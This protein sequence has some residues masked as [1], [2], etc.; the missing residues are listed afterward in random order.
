MI[1]P[2]PGNDRFRFVFSPVL[3]GLL[4]GLTLSLPVFGQVAQS[5][6]N[7]VASVASDS[8][9]A[10]RIDWNEVSSHEQKMIIRLLEAPDWPLRV[11]ALLRLER[12]SGKTVEQ[13]ILKHV[14]DE[15]WQA[16]CFA[17]RQ[18]YQMGIKVT[19]ESLANETEPRVIRTALRYGV[20]LDEKFITRGVKKLL[21][22]RDIDQLLLG[23]EIAAA[24]DIESLREEATKRLARF[25]S[26]M[27]DS[28]STRVTR[29]LVRVVGLTQTP[30]GITQWRKWYK[31]N[32]KTFSLTPPASQQP[33]VIEPITMVAE[34]DIDAFSRLLDYLDFLRQ[35]DLELVIVMDFTASMLLMIN[36]A[37]AGVDSLILFLNDIS[38]TMSL[39]FVAY[40]DHDNEPVFEK[41]DLADNVRSVRDFLFNLPVT[42]GEDYP[43]AVLDGMAACGGM[44]WNQNATRQI[45]LVGDAPPH[46]H[47]IYQ[48]NNLIDSFRSDGITIHAVHILLPRNRDIPN[49]WYSYNAKAGRDF[50]NIA[51]RGNGRMVTLSDA[52]ALVPAVMHFTLDEGWWSIFD[53]F[54]EWYLDLCR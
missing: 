16:R 17:L 20:A 46:E 14:Q 27:N 19:G 3:I 10:T 21:R 24:S 9:P 34:M 6:R 5:P 43:E 33:A 45:I 44:E 22:M 29:R 32:R 51:E 25:I 52:E 40:R 13:F 50:A 23:I 47:D 35:R 7:G 28:V 1:T 39:G 15:A 2:R 30:S 12:F 8:A 48:L 37:R 36:Q 4:W 49:F 42:G 26:R 18:S 38:R 53:E 54:Y 31:K 11:F 41:H